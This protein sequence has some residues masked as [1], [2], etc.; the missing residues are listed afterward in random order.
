[1]AEIRGIID[2]VYRESRGVCEGHSRLSRFHHRRS[3]NAAQMCLF[4]SYGKFQGIL[5]MLFGCKMNIEAIV[6]I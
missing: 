1:M 3:D 6:F 2:E 4:G 5:R